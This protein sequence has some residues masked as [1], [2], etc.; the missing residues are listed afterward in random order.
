LNS[1]SGVLWGA[2]NLVSFNFLL[3]LTPDAQRARFSAF[4]QILVM[5]ALAGGAAV[6]AWV[7]TS[8]G[9]QAIFLC[10]AIGRMAAAVLFVRFV[11]AMSER[12][13]TLG[14]G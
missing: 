7:V 8:W 9:Y 12:S 11:P 5:L 6:G 4:Y 1:F 3:S 2:F 13:E 14:M 10:S